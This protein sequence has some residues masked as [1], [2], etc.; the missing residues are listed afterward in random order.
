MVVIPTSVRTAI[1][2]RE[3]AEAKRR[4]QVWR[5]FVCGDVHIKDGKLVIV[6]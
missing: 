2:E 4:Q 6:L 3:K 1:A 5:V